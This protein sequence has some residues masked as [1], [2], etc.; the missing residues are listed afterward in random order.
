MADVQ[1]EKVI[2]LGSGPAGL[3]AGIYTAR[4][5]LSPLILAGPML[6]GQVS[7]TADVENYPGFPDGL[8]GPELVE[9][10]QKQAERFGARIEYAEAV[11]TDFSQGSPFRIKDSGGKE[12]EAESIL[13]LAYDAW[14]KYK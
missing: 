3:T 6:G 12:Y 11:E 2:I 8:G 10:M 9:R 13:T 1:K 5:S 7:I 14:K 4:A